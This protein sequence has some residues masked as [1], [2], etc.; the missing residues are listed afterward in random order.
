MSVWWLCP[1]SR[2]V[3]ARAATTELRLG[4]VVEPDPAY[5]LSTFTCDQRSTDHD[6]TII[7][8]LSDSF[9]CD[10]EYDKLYEAQ[11]LQT[12][13]AERA[14]VVRQMQQ[15]LYDSNAYVVTVNYDSVG[16]DVPEDVAR[17]EAILK[18][19]GRQ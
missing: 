2:R 11:K 19:A 5:Q 14:A 16:V 10:A 3:W 8:G 4:W 17:V 18:S 12:D 15:M 7:A 6:G 9:Y 1:V 13:P